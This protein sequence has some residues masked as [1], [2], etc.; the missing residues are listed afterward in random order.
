MR[1]IRTRVRCRFEWICR[2]GVIMPLSS[3]RVTA[4]WGWC[5]GAGPGAGEWPSPACRLIT[6]SDVHE[7]DAAG[8]IAPKWRTFT[9]SGT[10]VGLRLGELSGLHGHRGGL[11]A[12]T[13][14]RGRRED[15]PGVAAVP[16][17]IAS[18]SRRRGAPVAHGP[19]R[20]DAL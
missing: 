8:E 6:M 16:E 19:V 1:T 12:R 13:D 7:G 4:G 14:H 10:Q 5:P 3:Q 2:P 17:V 11:A 20:R 9:E 18:W 15:A